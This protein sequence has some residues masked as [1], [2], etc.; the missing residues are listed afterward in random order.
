M[1]ITLHRVNKIEM[2]ET[3]YEE[4]TDTAHKAP[5]KFNCITLNVY[6]ES[7]QVVSLKLFPESNKNFNELLENQGVE[8]AANR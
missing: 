7:N 8:Y 1:E 5:W 3:I 2:R 4:T 6:D